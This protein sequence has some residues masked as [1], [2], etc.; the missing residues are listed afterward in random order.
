MV[1][2]LPNGAN[3]TAGIL[4]EHRIGPGASIGL[5]PTG[6]HHP[7]TFPHRTEDTPVNAAGIQLV[8][9]GLI[10]W[11]AASAP[12]TLATVDQAFGGH[13]VHSREWNGAKQGVHI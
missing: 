3:W 6:Q 12:P 9:P 4:Q 5:A 11:M 10:A 2:P 7:S 8:H 13:L 1:R